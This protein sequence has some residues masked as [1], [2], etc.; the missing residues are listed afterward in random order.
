MSRGL[1]RIER[2]CLRVIEEYSSRRKRVTTNRI[3][4]KVYQ[5]KPDRRGVL[6]INDAQHTAVKRALAGLRRKG[7]V[8]GQQAVGRCP[9]GRMTL[10]RCS[11]IDGSAVRECYWS[12]PASPDLDV[13][14]DPG[15]VKSHARLAVEL[16]MSM[17]AVRRARAKQ[18]MS[19]DHTKQSD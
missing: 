6:I 17:P 7:L 18:A 8:K 14:D 16:G 15:N 3:V 4:A 13:T 2:E 19:P 12:T 9:D 1:G 5:V 11:N 10:A